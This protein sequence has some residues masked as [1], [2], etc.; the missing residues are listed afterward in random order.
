[1]QMQVQELKKYTDLKVE[2]EICCSNGGSGR[3]LSLSLKN[4][5][6]RWTARTQSSTAARSLAGDALVWA[7]N[8]VREPD[9]FAAVVAAVATA[10]TAYLARGTEETT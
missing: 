6:R 10:L 1:M 4:F 9:K 8:Y 3:M 5:G 7:K 2:V